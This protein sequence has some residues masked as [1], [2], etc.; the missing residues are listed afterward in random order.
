LTN[1]DILPPTGAIVIAA[2]LKIKEGSGSPLRVFALVPT[3]VRAPTRN[4]DKSV[5]KG[6]SRK[7]R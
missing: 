7:K 2:P 1:L 3:A 5:K 4:S 6:R